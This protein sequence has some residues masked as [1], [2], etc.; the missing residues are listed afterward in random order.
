MVWQRRYHKSGETDGGMS[1]DIVSQLD[2]VKVK[3]SF[4]A[5]EWFD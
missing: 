5:I 4:M 2:K 1:G 3:D